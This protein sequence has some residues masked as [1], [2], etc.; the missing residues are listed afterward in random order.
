[1]EQV[2]EKQRQKQLERE[3]KM[4]EDAEEERKL[5]AERDRLQRQFEVDQ[6][7]LKVREVRIN[8][9]LTMLK[10]NHSLW[11]IVFVVLGVI[12]RNKKKIVLSLNSYQGLSKYE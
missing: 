5:Q 10:K 9:L 3:R 6:S 11:G 12:F 1:M 2:Q 4:A 8:R 7:K